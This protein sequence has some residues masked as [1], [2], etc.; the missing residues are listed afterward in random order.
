MLSYWTQTEFSQRHLRRIARIV[1]QPCPYPKGSIRRIKWYMWR[2]L[3]GFDKYL[4]GDSEEIVAA[5]D[6]SRLRPR[7]RGSDASAV[8][9][10]VD[11]RGTV[12]DAF[13]SL[14]HGC[15]QRIKPRFSLR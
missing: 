10:R 7:G 6:P 4:P 13:V 14:G 8:D 12:S 5:D 9:L 11:S 3:V 2:E 1:I 15:K